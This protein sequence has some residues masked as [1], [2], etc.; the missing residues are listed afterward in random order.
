MTVLTK[1]Y[2]AELDNALAFL[3]EGDDFLVVSHVQPDGDA[4]SSTLIMN[5]LLK[6]LGKRVTMINEGN[7]P[8]RLAYLEESDQIIDYSL[9][10]PGRTY[11]RI[12]A[13]DCADFRRIGQ[14]S[15]LFEQGR[16]LLNI[17]HH[18]TND[19]F[20]TVNVIR[21]NA[22]A[23][24]EILFDLIERSGIPLEVGAGTAVYTGLLTDTGGFRYSSTSPHVMRIASKLLEIG[25]KG[26][27]LADH[28]L[29]KMTMPQLK[30]L[31]RGLSRLT[32]TED[33]RVG[34]LYIEP[35]DMADT[36]AAPEDLEGLVN[37]ARN[38][39]GVECGMLFKVTAEGDVKVSL[40]SA[41]RLDV[42]AVA[43]LYGGGGHVRAA[44][45]R[46]RGPLADA[47]A[48]VVDTV[49]KALD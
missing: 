35:S 48:A 13:V 33:G 32:F 10:N 2:L 7:F 24:A 36:G 15:E 42:A 40:R 21:S 18:P 31:Q 29:E 20:G 27:E 1:E 22:A 14:V 47:M 16:E 49:R 43:Q 25:V 23:T 19:G 38:I 37:Y 17:D 4:I 9:T 3:R 12:V 41:G 44:G 5:W 11:D 28:L 6:K 30:V 45:C 8:A 46:V 34:W 26:F 39:D